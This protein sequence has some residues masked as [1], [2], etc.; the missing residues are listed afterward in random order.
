M[1]LETIGVIAVFVLL[2]SA[3]AIM[4][5]TEKWRAARASRS[6][7]KKQFGIQKTTI[8]SRMTSLNEKRR[9]LV[10]DMSMSTAAYAILTIV[11]AGVGA[12]AGRALFQEI[13][14]IAILAILGAAAPLLYLTYRRTKLGGQRIDKLLTS[15]SMLSNSF[16]AT[17]D[18]IASVRENVGRLEEPA[19]FR[20][21]LAYVS[22]IN[23]DTV[24][25]LH[26]LDSRV[27]NPYFTEWI[28][29]IIMA[30][31]DRKMKYATIPIVDML[32]D[33]RQAQMEAD[34]AMYGIWYEYL[35]VLVLIFCAPIVM[36]LL[37]ADAYAILV[38]SP[39]GQLL[40][41]LL[42]VAVV[43]S[44]LR[45]VKLNKPVLA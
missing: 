40:L 7:M 36:R 45:A 20:D 34:T 24:A 19:P 32:N 25:A 42:V 18:F 41:V 4:L 11:C 15:M 14:F 27:D 10:S 38:T 12:V 22:Y 29:A 44:L 39:I 35:T 21:F 8:W 28:S 17:E 26:R 6:Q 31:E 16:I 33:V 43:Y 2:C 23:G 30:Q 37:M 1:T 3:A 13:L 5:N 9:N